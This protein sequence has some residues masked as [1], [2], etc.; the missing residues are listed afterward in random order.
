MATTLPLFGS[1]LNTALAR[2]HFTTPSGLSIPGILARLFHEIQEKGTVTSLNKFSSFL[3][4][5]HFYP[6]TGLDIEGIFRKSSSTTVVN[7]LQAQFEDNPNPFLLNFPSTL[8][9]HSLA[10]L[11]K[12]YLQLLPEPVIPRRFQPAFLD[13]F[14]EEKCTKETLKRRLKEI[15]KTLPHE[16]LHLLQFLMEVADMVQQ[17]QDRNQMSIESLAIIFAPTCVR[18]D[19]VSQLMMPHSGSSKLYPITGGNKTASASYTSLPLKLNRQ[20]VLRKARQIILSAIHKKSAPK[21]DRVAYDHSAILYK[22]N[23]LLQLELIKE[24]NT[25]VRI[26]AFMIS[27]PEVF[28]TLTNP[29]KSQKY[30]QRPSFQTTRSSNTINEKKEET[31]HNTPS[32]NK[33]DLSSFTQQEKKMLI[34]FKNIEFTEPHDLVKTFEKFE[35]NFDKEKPKRTSRSNSVSSIIHQPTVPSKYVETLLNWKS[36]EEENPHVIIPQVV[37]KRPLSSVT[38]RPSSPQP[39]DWLKALS[40]GAFEPTEKR[41]RQPLFIQIEKNTTP[42]HHH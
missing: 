27:H 28:T 13:I 35:I 17:N 25:W 15:C 33:P 41:I 1:P 11:F 18:I 19:G 34:D 38:S 26:F 5:T 6:K 23:D 10:G 22:P 9:T 16:H 42:L 36:R 14:D 8:S 7:Q 40:G 29:L 20:Q 24:S 37:I 30:Q 4:V 21:Y 31:V 12:R 3:I 2:S 32:P 39:S